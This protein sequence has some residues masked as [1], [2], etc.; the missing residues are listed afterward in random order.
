MKILKNSS[1]FGLS[2]T[3]NIGIKKATGDYIVFLDSDDYLVPDQLQLIL[4]EENIDK[5]SNI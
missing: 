5:D 4:T 3:R 1:N 2:E